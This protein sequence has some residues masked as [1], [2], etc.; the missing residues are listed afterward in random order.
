MCSSDLA[1]QNGIPKGLVKDHW[2][3]FGPRIGFAYDLTGEGKTVIRGGFGVMYERIQGNDMY[4]AGP[5]IPFSS[6][7]TF[8]NVSLSNPNTSLSTGQTIT[9]PVTVASITGLSNTDYKLPVSY[10]YSLGVQRELWRDGVISV[11]YVGNQNCHQNDYRD[12]NLPSPS[13]LPALI[14]GDA[15]TPYN[16]QVPYLGFHSITLSEN[17]ENS[18]YNSLQVNM[19]SRVRK[20]LTLQVAYTLSRA[21]DPATSF[22]GDLYTV[23]NP[24]N[25]AYDNEIGRAHV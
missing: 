3:A 1:G 13:V 20:D 16:Q 14:A 24:Y 4:N 8:N 23:S 19:H 7:V 17:A 21:I 10:Q 12:I 18:H 22:G 2:A 11:A 25:R 15:N 6:S 9:A 5:N